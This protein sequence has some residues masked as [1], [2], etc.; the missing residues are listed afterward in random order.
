VSPQLLKDINVGTHGSFLASP[1]M[2]AAGLTFFAANDGTHG[3]ELWRTD[4]TAAGTVMVKDI[5]PGPGD[6]NPSY[7]TNRNGQLVFVAND[8]VHGAE[9]WRSNGTAAGTVLVRDINPGSAGSFAAPPS[10]AASLTNVN[11]VVFFAADDGVHG[12]ELWRS[13]GTAGGTQLVSD[14]NAGGNPPASSSPRFL[15][16][17]NGTL[18]FSADDGVHGRE[19]WR[20]NGAAAGTTIVSDIFPG[21]TSGLPYYL[22]NV[23]GTLFFNAQDDVH[24]PELW[25]SD[26]TPGGTS[27]V[28]DAVPGGS[29]SYPRYLTSVNGA[30]FFIAFDRSTGYELWHSDGTAAG[31]AL[32][33]DINPGPSNSYLSELTNVNGDLFFSADDGTH[34]PELW[35][36]D[37]T[38]AGTALVKDI[39]PGPTGSLLEGS[40]I[41]LTNVNG[42][43]FF[44]ANDVIHGQELWRSD[45]TAFGTVLVTDLLPGP[46]GSFPGSLTNSNGTLF[47]G[48]FTPAVGSELWRSNGVAAGTALV[49]DI[50]TTA[51]DSNPSGFTAVGSS[52]FF[53]ANDATHGAELWRTNGAAAGTFLVKDISPG[54]FGSYPSFLTNVSGTLFFAASELGDGNELWRSD[55]TAAGTVL[56]KDIN[57]GSHSSITTGNLLNV[58]GT[59]FFVADD[60]A[61]GKELWK[62][63]GTAAGTRLVR[64][65]NPGSGS[66]GP[67]GLTNVNGTLFFTADDGAHGRELWKSNGTPAGTM[68]VKDIYPGLGGSAPNYLTNVN[69]VLF[70]SANDGINNRTG[71]GD[72]LWRSNGTPQGTFLVKDINPDRPNG[73]PE[74]S[75][76]H[77]LTNVNGTLF[78]AATNP[79][80]GTE[81]WKSNGAAAGTVLVKDI[82]PGVANFAPLGSYPQGLTNVNGTLFFSA[83]NGVSG[84]E[85]WKSN[86][87]TAGTVLIK[88]INPGS[89][90]GAPNSSDPSYLKNVNGTLFFSASNGIS[91]MEL[92]TS[93]GSASGTFLVRD[94]NP[95]AA[96]SSPMFLTAAGS[97]LFFSAADG[98]HGREP[99]V[100]KTTAT[101]ATSAAIV[102]S[103]PRADPSA[104]RPRA[105]SSESGQLDR[106]RAFVAPVPSPAAALA[107]TAR[108]TPLPHRAR[109][110]PTT[111]GSEHWGIGE[112]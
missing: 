56:V 87:A 51:G 33:K 2:Q 76:P 64:D 58:N 101:S 15:T 110:P 3:V 1:F 50:N 26:G 92:W 103:A 17:V 83:N 9:L 111:D 78:F 8:G 93:N 4:G 80:T 79:A 112:L 22:I 37:G 61:H 81:L 23:N 18:L 59:L 49:K 43:L 71:S 53:T 20:S 102:F 28:A 69:G 86:G 84:R 55:G 96:G 95:G 36:S 27:L 46:D 57:R 82:N 10:L 91:G 106:P 29:G 16:N 74:S 94:I 100:L 19:L 88:D 52:V 13:D 98:V 75:Y 48:A 5:N 65:I 70:F 99:W 35:H 77:D 31:T 7:L 85:L 6:S 41:S 25:R 107:D 47:F 40:S 104:P 30:L 67:T 72:E 68:L 108:A 109:I 105:L 60:G 54:L 63:N 39:V 14:I 45:G 38:A 66:S 89:S 21:G 12:V 62:S 42:T 34:G 32:V 90:G 44:S 73:L 24:G 11:G 97:T